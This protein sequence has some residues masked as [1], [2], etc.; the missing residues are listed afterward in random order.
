M[1][2]RWRRAL[3]RRENGGRDHRSAPDPEALATIGIDLDEVRRR[4]EEAFGPGAL[5]K[6]SE[7]RSVGARGP[8]GR[9]SGHIPFS[10]RAKKVLDCRC[11]RRWP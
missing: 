7:D 3:S 8:E 2:Q 10:P 4:I 1:R 5:D 9:R 6:R 11:A